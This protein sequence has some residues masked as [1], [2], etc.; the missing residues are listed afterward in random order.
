GLTLVAAML[1]GCAT[2]RAPG[3]TPPP[4]AAGDPAR[5]ASSPG[6]SQREA[7]ARDLLGMGD[8]D[9]AAEELRALLRRAPDDV[10]VRYLLAV[11]LMAK[12]DW[13]SARSELAAV[14]RR[15]PDLVPAYYSLGLV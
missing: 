15:Q 4:G 9:G 11:A 6:V 12:Q 7:R 8:I 1:A 3:S 5:A 13:A 10:R 14:L 2:G